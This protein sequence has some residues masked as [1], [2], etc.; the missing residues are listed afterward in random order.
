MPVAKEF[1]T[2]ID[3]A[4]VR[5][6]RQRE[7][8]RGRLV[9]A[10]GVAMGLAGGAGFEMRVLRFEQKDPRYPLRS[11]WRPRSVRCQLLLAEFVV[12]A[13]RAAALALTFLEECEALL[14]HVH[15]AIQIDEIAAVLFFAALLVALLEPLQLSILQRRLLRR[16]QVGAQARVL[17]IQVAVGL[18]KDRAR[19]IDLIEGVTGLTAT[20]GMRRQREECSGYDNGEFL[21]GFSFLLIHETKKQPFIASRMAIHDAFGDCIGQLVDRGR[22][23][24]SSLFVGIDDDPGF[25][26]HCRHAGRFEH[27]QIVEFVN[28]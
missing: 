15:G 16:I 22:L 21:H 5:D 26:Q 10:C 9:V 8:R 4:S 23:C 2:L 3:R 17:L 14:R 20:G 11:G 28:T 27:D 13:A 1:D 7:A 12:G 25:H 18:R 24:Q 6:L 19:A